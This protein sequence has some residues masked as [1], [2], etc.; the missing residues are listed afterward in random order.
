[1]AVEE[2]SMFFFVV[3]DSKPSSLWLYLFTVARW[4]SLLTCL[5]TFLDVNCLTAGLGR[6]FALEWRSIMV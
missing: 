4:P 3:L 5:S 1:M 6:N 2:R